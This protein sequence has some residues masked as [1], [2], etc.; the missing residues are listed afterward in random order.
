MAKSIAVYRDM[1]NITIT[2]ED[3]KTPAPLT[4]ERLVA[5]DIFQYEQENREWSKE[6]FLM[7]N[8]SITQIGQCVSF[9][10]GTNTWMFLDRPCRKFNKVVISEVQDSEPFLS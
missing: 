7:L 8:P 5:G 9:I 6:V 10:D 2:V 1:K 3:K 4:I